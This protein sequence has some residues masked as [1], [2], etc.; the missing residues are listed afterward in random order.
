MKRL[1]TCILSLTILLVFSCASASAL[2]VNV[3]EANLRGDPSTKQE[4]T[5][6]VFKY[7]PFSKLSRKGNWFKVKDVDGDI[8]WIYSKLVTDKY[9]C[10]VV[11]TE[12]VNV[13][14]GPGTKYKKNILSP[15]PKY[16]S[17]K[18][19]DTKS[20]WVKVMDEDGDTGWIHKKLLWIQ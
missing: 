11:K 6:T 2:C 15:S 12:T 8:H 16:T 9:K 13:R 1:L 18:V 5:W 14:S 17:F 20:S 3:S 10:A 7:M 4:K 19:I